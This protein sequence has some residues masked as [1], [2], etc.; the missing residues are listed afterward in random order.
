MWD[1]LQITHEDTIELKREMLDTLYHEYEFLTMKHEESINP[2]QTRFTHIMSHMRTLG[3]TFSNE[4]MVINIFRFLNCSW[5]P[6]VVAICEYKNLAT[7]DT[8]TL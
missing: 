5:Q 2:M 4:D 3:K 1:I 7:M 8:H 6:K